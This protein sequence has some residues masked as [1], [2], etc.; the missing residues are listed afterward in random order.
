MIQS[1]LFPS[2]G[3][4]FRLQVRRLLNRQGQVLGSNDARQQQTPETASLCKFSHLPLH[5]SLSIRAFSHEAV[6]SIPTNSLDVPDAVTVESTEDFSVE[7]VILALDK[8]ATFNQG[9]GAS[10]DSHKTQRMWNVDEVRRTVEQYEF[11]LRNFYQEKQGLENTVLRGLTPELKALFLSSQTTEKAFR[12]MLRCRVPTSVLSEKVREWEQYVGSLGLTPLTDTLSQ[13]ML[14]ANGKAGNIGRAMK[15][16]SLRESRGYE[17]T[18]LEFVHA[19]TAIEAAGLYLRKHRNVFLGDADQPQIDDPT[20]WL[21]AIL[22]NMSQRNFPLTI[23]LANRMLNTFASTGKT[24]KASHF[25]YRV[26]RSPI[27]E[28]DEFPDESTIAGMA[29]F[30]QKPVKVRVSMRPPPPYHKIPSQV[31]GKLVRKPGTEMKQLKLDRESDPDWSPPLTAAITFADSLTQGACG[32][33]PI[34]LDLVSYSILIKACVN[35]G[36]CW[37]AMHILDEVM[38]SKGIEPDVVAYNTLL[39]GL[40]RAGDA[41]TMKEYF[42]KM[43]SKNIRPTKET[44]EAIVT[45]LLNLGDVTTAITFVQDCFNQYSVLPPYTTHLKILEVSLGRGLV[46]EARRHVFVIRQLMK[47]ERNEYHSKDF[48]RLMEL[49]QMNPKLSKKALQDLFLYF[50][51]KLDDS[52]FL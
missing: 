23:E 35:R 36:S 11:I 7:S 28:D 6:R 45:G 48:C 13:R 50:G 1:I 29:K 14:E 46:Y 5:S 26:L 39:Y 41:P 44:V 19:I 9:K 12:A 4:N 2:R 17:P 25:F 40:A 49:T 37:R 52:H 21:D 42:N 3:L 43:N 34:E 33:D 32:H 38:P 47:W 31:K 15:L 30:H 18:R 8:A 22:M 51:E 10:A 16:L 20:R 27:E 24:G